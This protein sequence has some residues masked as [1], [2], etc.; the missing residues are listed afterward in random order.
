MNAANFA[1]SSPRY[2]DKDLSGNLY[3]VENNSDGPTIKRMSS[4]WPYVIS[5]IVTI[6]AINSITI[7]RQNNLLYATDGNAIYKTDLSSSAPV[8][9]KITGGNAVGIVD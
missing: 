1:L 6:P 4:V 5:K 8:A 7:D 9:T 3:F 2:L